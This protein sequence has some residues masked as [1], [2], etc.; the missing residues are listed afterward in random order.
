MPQFEPY[1]PSKNARQDGKYTDIDPKKICRLEIFPPIGIS[2]LGDS[3]DEYFY[4]PEVPGGTDHHFGKFRDGDQKIRRQAA[5]FRVYAYGEGDTALGEVNLANGYQL[6]WKVHVANKKPA[7]YHS[8]GQYRVREGDPDPK[9]LRNPDVQSVSEDRLTGEPFD[10]SMESRDK[11]IIDP[12]A[13][14]I[15]REPNGP[16]DPC[17]ELSAPFHGSKDQP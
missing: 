3:N 9:R 5:R 2:R 17:V 10:E 16:S 12:G 13:K 4:G 14:T 7:Y 1:D 11:L 6:N 15:T 8:R